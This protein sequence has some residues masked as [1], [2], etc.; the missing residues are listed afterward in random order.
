M[1]EKCPICEAT[2]INGTDSKLKITYPPEKLQEF[3]AGLLSI[4]QLNE[5]ALFHYERHRLCPNHGNR[6][7]IIEDGVER[8]I[9]PPCQN[10]YGIRGGTIEVPDVVVEIIKIEDN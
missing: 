1:L 6:D 8:F 5:F 3:A 9:A 4:E 7:T 2:L 10:Y